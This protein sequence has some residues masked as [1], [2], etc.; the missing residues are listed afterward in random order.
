MGEHACV[1]MW[2]RC[3]CPPIPERGKAMERLLSIVPAAGSAVMDW[4]AVETLL[5]DILLPLADT[6]Q[7]PR[8]HGEGNVWIHTKMMVQSLLELPEYQQL[9]EEERQIVFLSA[10]FHDVGKPQCTRRE[11][12]QWVSRGHGRA[13]EQIVR[14]KLWLDHDLCGTPEKQQFRETVCRLIRFHSTPVHA[15]DDADGMRRLR[16]IASCGELLPRFS[17]RLLCLLSEADVRGRINPETRKQLEKIELCRMLAREAGCYEHPFAFPSN[18]TRYS[19]LSGKDILPEQPLYD[20]TWGQVI[21]LSGLP[22]VGK[23]TWIR[24]NFP[25]LPMISL[26]D[27]RRELDYGATK[28]Q[29]VIAQEGHR[30]AKEFL[31]KKQPFVWNATDISPMI[32]QKQID[33]FTG[34]GASVQIVYLETGWQEQRRRNAERAAAVPESAI[35]RMLEKLEPPYP[36]EAHQ[37]SW[38]CL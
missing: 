23:D 6:P 4:K 14:R 22:G 32:R 5:G 21:L 19:Y 34:Y 26:D 31:R 1:W 8:W 35:C 38:K 13:G 2:M 28:N 7:S 30:R 33:L 3:S 10:L 20:T 17:L 16:M 11:D 25:E 18:Y 24:E 12:G 9:P 36:A 37:V 27:I 15:I 29:A